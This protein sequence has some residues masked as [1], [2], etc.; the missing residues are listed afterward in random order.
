MPV[1]PHCGGEV[2]IPGPPPVPWWK[3]EFGPHPVNL[4]CGSL[5][6]IAIIVAFCSGGFGAAGKIERLDAD[7]QRLER[8]VDELSRAV[9]RL[10][11]K[12]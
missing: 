1:C 4:G 9:D 3:R 11:K 7:I 6:L 12:P 5:I 2:E 8:T 10:A